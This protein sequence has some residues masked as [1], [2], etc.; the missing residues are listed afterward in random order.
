MARIDIHTHVMLS[1]KSI[2]KEFSVQATFEE[3]RDEENREAI[4][5]AL[6]ANQDAWKGLDPEKV[7][8]GELIRAALTDSANA[9]QQ[10]FGPGSRFCVV[11]E[12][13]MGTPNGERMA[14][15]SSRTEIVRD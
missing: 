8:L 14:H 6:L 2:A 13:L 9:V 5:L 7:S 4:A 10:S 15:V 11:L 1:L 12:L 3:L